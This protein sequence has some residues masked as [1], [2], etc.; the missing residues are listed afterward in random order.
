MAARREADQ[1]GTVLDSDQGDFIE[2]DAP[3]TSEDAPLVASDSFEDLTYGDLAEDDHPVVHKGTI[4]AI[5]R[6]T[7]FDSRSDTPNN[8]DPDSSEVSAGE[9]SLEENPDVMCLI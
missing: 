4:N 5:V 6:Q 1:S 8:V 2:T 9:E 7:S 3:G